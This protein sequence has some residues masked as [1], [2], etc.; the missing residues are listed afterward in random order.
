[1]FR[2]IQFRWEIF[3]LERR[4]RKDREG[5]DRA[6]EAAKARRASEEEI[7]E[8]AGGSSEGVIRYRIRQIMSGYLEW[9]ALRLFVPLPDEKEWDSAGT[10]SRDAISKLSAAIRAERKARIELL[11]MWVPGVTG[12]L[13]A[14]IGL[15]AIL[16][17]KGK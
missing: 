15:A 11:L 1:M 3:Q 5:T 14:M 2:Y 16:V 6:I 9:E 13:G 7:N 17:G 12:I 8:I 4:A 10:L